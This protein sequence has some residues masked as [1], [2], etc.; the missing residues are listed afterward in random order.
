MPKPAR[1]AATTGP[2][3]G[4][5]PAA[6]GRRHRLRARLRAT[7]SVIPRAAALVA[8]IVSFGGLTDA[9]LPT[10][11]AQYPN[12]YA[13]PTLPT[14]LPWYAPT[15]TPTPLGA[16]PGGPWPPAQTLPPPS[17]YGPDPAALP[18]G[19]LPGGAIV[20]GAVPQASPATPDLCYG[21]E[22]ITFAPEGPRVGN[23]LLIAVTSG[24]PHPYGRLVGTEKTQFVRERLGQRGYV[25][26]WVVQPTYPGQHEY[27]FYVD[28]TVLCQKIQLRVLRSL[29]TST[30]KPPEAY[31]YDYGNTNSK[32]NVAYDAPY[33]DPTYPMYY[34]TYP[35]ATTGPYPGAFNPIAYLNQ[36]DRYGCRDFASQANAQ[37]VLRADPTDPNRL[38]TDPR[39]GLACGNAEAERDGVAGGFMPPPF[40]PTRV[41]RP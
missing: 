39:D 27:T 26:E 2:S 10:A 36:G 13:T 40:D 20:P 18:P 37:A 35:I 11:S 38:D 28:S 21:D 1:S 33:Y 19:G 34:P 9:S 30:P 16:G 22:L 12:P 6:R 15:S 23:D 3:G 29:A 7:L 4:V 8:L 31:G 5:S 32:D 25:W 17:G 41:P 14:N 24:R